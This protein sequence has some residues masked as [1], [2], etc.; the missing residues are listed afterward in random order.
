MVVVDIIALAISKEAQTHLHKVKRGFSALQIQ[1]PPGEG[2]RTR[3][4]A[5]RRGTRRAPLARV[6]VGCTSGV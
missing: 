1:T 5:P 6:L 4:D 3:H 2:L